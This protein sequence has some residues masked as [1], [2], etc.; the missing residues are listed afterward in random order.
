LVASGKATTFVEGMRLASESVDGGH[1]I[2]KLRAM[3]E[4]SSV[5]TA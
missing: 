4:F 3:V 5:V 2:S 1:A